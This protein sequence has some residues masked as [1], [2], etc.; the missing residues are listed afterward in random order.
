MK[1]QPET[2]PPQSLDVEEM[3]LGGILVDPNAIGRVKNLLVPDDFYLLAHGL[4]YSL[5]LELHQKGTPIDLTQVANYMAD[6]NLLDSVGGQGKLARLYDTTP[7]AINIDHYARLLRKK[8]IARGVIRIGEK[9]SNQAYQAD[10]E[11]E[12]L[13]QKVSGIYRSLDQY[14]CISGLGL[15]RVSES[16]AQSFAEIERLSLQ[17]IAPGLMSGFYD[18]DQL[19]SGF[20]NSDLIVIAGR[21]GMGKTAEAT[22]MGLNMS[23]LGKTVAFFSMEMSRES[24]VY[25]LLSM[26]AK[27]ESSRMKAGQIRDNEWTKIVNACSILSDIPF[28]IDSQGGLSVEAIES[29]LD[30]L[31]S[32]TGTK[33]DAVFIDYLQLMQGRSNF[34][35]NKNQEIGAITNALKSMAMKRN[36]PVF[37]LSQLSRGVESRADKRPQ[38]PDLRDSG[39]IEQDAD[40]VL[41][42][43][44][45]EYYDPNTVDRGIAEIILAKHR[46]GPTG[47]VKVLFDSRYTSFLNLA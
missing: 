27:I 28:F 41:L 2:V 7:D 47:V 37:I 4:I 39:S 32:R 17:G 5:M 34:G 19:T 33:V 16:L 22:Q 36:I 40:L 11:S 29:R 31:E 10:L 20:Q 23:T 38:M 1:F 46:N 8:S 35:G 44:R 30:S 14:R 24:L 42:L 15:R 43:Y 45:D 21:P 12:E 6:R 13:L 9:I 3:V 18:L 25:R 26:L